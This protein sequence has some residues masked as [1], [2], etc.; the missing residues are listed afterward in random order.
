MHRILIPLV[1]LTP[2]FAWAG[3]AVEEAASLKKFAESFVARQASDL[4][5]QV[6]AVAG[7]IDPRLRLPKCPA[8]E[9][10]I[11]PGTRLWGNASIGIRC[12]DP[13]WSIY[14]PVTVKVMAMA[15]V[16]AKPLAQGQT[17][18]PQ[19]LLPQLTDLTQQAP[20]VVT[21]IEQ[22]IGK[23]LAAPLAAGQ[24]L[25][26]DQLRAPVVIKTGQVVKL[27]AQSSTFQVTSEGKALSSGSS[28]QTISIRTSSGKVVSGIIKG[29]GTVEVSF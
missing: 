28:G 15:M 20:G 21:D 17:L 4:P 10:F 9:G 26:T 12:V 13:A 2:F 14:V 22:A 3:P 23:T 27:V 7:T 8:A 16:A 18:S 1:F 24:A 11:P 5:G 25:R 29:D 6:T 19:D